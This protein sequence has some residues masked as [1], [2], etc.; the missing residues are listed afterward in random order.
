MVKLLK[1]LPKLFKECYLDTHEDYLRSFADITTYLYFKNNN[2]LEDGCE[3]MINNL[4]SA[5]KFSESMVDKSFESPYFRNL[6]N[7]WFH[8]VALNHPQDDLDQR[9]MQIFIPP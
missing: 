6:R 7:S 2:H 1:D 4:L 3:I 9:S 8:E 5:G